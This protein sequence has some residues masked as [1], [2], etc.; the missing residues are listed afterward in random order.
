M[1]YI[2]HRPKKCTAY[3]YEIAAIVFPVSVLLSHSLAL[4]KLEE[5]MCFSSASNMVAIYL[6]ESARIRDLHQIYAVHIITMCVFISSLYSPELIAYE[7]HGNSVTYCMALDTPAMYY[8]C[9]CI[10]NTY[11]SANI[12]GIVYFNLCHK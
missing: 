4:A 3:T 11:E 5:E 9:I 1:K 2:C 8:L 6:V 7:E 12:F 10:G